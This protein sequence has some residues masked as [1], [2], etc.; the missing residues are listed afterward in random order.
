MELL[1]GRKFAFIRGLGGLGLGFG[2]VRGFR[3]HKGFGGVGLKGLR[4][5]GFRGLGFWV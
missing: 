2:G 4:G 5:L 1:R 3:V